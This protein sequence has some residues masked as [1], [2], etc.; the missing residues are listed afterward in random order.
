MQNHANG[1][2]LKKR[3]IQIYQASLKDENL[4]QEIAMAKI[5]AVSDALAVQEKNRTN[6]LHLVQIGLVNVANHHNI[7]IEVSLYKEFKKL[8]QVNTEDIIKR[9]IFQ[10][11]AVNVYTIDD[12]DV[13]LLFDISE[14][15]TLLFGKAL[16]A[17]KKLIANHH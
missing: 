14:I 13:S 1:E 4:F 7:K 12:I 16:K 3:I 10:I 2:N 6:Q 9:K 11:G 17:I 5:A 8:F 15:K